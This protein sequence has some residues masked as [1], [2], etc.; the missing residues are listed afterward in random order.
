MKYTLLL[1]N[2]LEKANKVKEEF[3]CEYLYASHIAVAVADFCKNDY[4]GF[5]VSDMTYHPARFE[6]ERLR[7]IFRKEIKLASY[8]R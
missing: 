3:K 7:Y 4:T 6:E 2:I 8:F 1:T 5:F